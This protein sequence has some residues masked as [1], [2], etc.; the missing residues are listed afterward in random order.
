MTFLPYNDPV[1]QGADEMIYAL[2][3][4]QVPLDA[5][6]TLTVIYSDGKTIKYMQTVL[7]QWSFKIPT[8]AAI[9]TARYY[10]ECISPTSKRVASGQVLTFKVTAP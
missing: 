4:F 9:G 5:I 1:A 10:A 8:T 3:V 6:C 7:A 2:A